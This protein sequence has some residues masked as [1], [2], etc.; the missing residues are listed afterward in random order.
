M[1]VAQ[2]GVDLIQLIAYTEQGM[3]HFTLI[4]A[5]PGAG[6]KVCESSRCHSPGWQQISIY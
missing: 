5:R 4:I 6:Q 1:F 2:A 3:T